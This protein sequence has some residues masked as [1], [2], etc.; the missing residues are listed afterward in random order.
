MQDKAGELAMQQLHTLH[1]DE[2]ILQVEVL[3]PLTLNSYNAGPDR[4]GEAVRKYFE[5]PNNRDKRLTGQDLFLDI[6]NF[7][8]ERKDGLLAGYSEHARE[9]VPRIY[10]KA[11]VFKNKEE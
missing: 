11:K 1:G 6:A 9:Y 8:D 4:V 3:V 10:A 2:E 5:I 7:A